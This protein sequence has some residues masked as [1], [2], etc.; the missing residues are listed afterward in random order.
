[1]TTLVGLDLAGRRVLVV[2][3]GVVGTR[4]ARRLLED[5][6]QVVL[7]D[8]SPSDDARRMA[9]HGDVEVVERAV[10][11][12]ATSTG[13]WLVVAATADPA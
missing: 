4:R 2:G 8:P 9:S 13:A 6:A 5:G 7:V 11:E 10:V 12:S 3:A 1:M